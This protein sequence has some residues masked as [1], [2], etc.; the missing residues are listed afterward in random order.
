MQDLL[1]HGFTGINSE[2]VRVRVEVEVEHV[3]V[4]HVRKLPSCQVRNC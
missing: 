4:E 1:L 2:V 3:E